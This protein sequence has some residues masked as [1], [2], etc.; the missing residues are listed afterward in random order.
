MSEKILA[1]LHGSKLAEQILPYA[2]EQALSFQSK[3]FLFQSV[4]E[5]VVFSQ[6][7]PGAAPAPVQ[8]DV[9]LEGRRGP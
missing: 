9:L 6:G 1:Y 8:T 2:V 5:P 4:P 7:I 3:L